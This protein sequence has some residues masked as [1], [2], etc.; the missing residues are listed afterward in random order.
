[1][2]DLETIPHLPGCYLYLD[3]DGKVLYVGKAKDLKKKG[4]QLLPET[5]PR[6][7]DRE[8]DPYGIEPGLHSHKQR[9]RGPAQ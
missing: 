3:A 7:E 9:S 4:E 1:M 5:R 8:P 2:I 6:L